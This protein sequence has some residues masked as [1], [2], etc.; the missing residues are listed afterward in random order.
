MKEIFFSMGWQNIIES[1]LRDL[2]LS[3]YDVEKITGVSNVILHK[4][5][6]GKTQNPT[7]NTIKRLEEGLNIKI[8][9]RN[10][11]KITYTKLEEERNNGFG[12][13]VEIYKYPLF[14]K[15]SAGITDM[16]KQHSGNF[17]YLPA[18]KSD[19]SFAL[20]ISASSG[21]LNSGDVILIDPRAE[22]TNGKLSAALLKDGR[23]LI[24][25]YR[26]L[27]DGLIMIYYDNPEQEP[28][29]VKHNECYFVYRV[30]G[31]YKE[32]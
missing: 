2:R 26:Q 25:R 22:L 31:I 4:L 28:V 10:P 21:S 9:D 20:R 1:I 6:T 24:G 5:K 17:T 16:V 27:Q 18:K 15:L 8:D 32:V 11:E 12:N 19:G 7:Q 29:T 30:V 23:Q 14:E 3:I 13:R